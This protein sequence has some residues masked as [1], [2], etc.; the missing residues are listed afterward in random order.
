[1]Q[2]CEEEGLGL[3]VYSP[4]AQ[5]LLTGKY[6]KDNIPEGSRAA[7]ERAQ[8]A[9]PW[10]RMTEENFQ[11]LDQL[12]TVAQKLDCSLPQ[13]ALAWILRK[14]PISSAIIGAS[15][16]EQIQDNLK[17]TQVA[18]NAAVQEEI[19]QILANAPYDQYTGNRIGHGY[20][21]PNK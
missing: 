18:F 12:K 7:D 16:P 11:K 3:I 9:F 13:L 17:A 6:G 5:G 21:H 8:R 1:M 20:D 2:V 15:K 10:K 14:K 19:E 4:L